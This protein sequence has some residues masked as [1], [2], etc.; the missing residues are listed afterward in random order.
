M[1]EIDLK[2]K[3]KSVFEYESESIPRVGETLDISHDEVSGNFRVVNVRH[4]IFQDKKTKDV[5]TYV[6]VEV[7]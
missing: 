6:V 3:G 7:E 2:I 1:T 5:R 4:R